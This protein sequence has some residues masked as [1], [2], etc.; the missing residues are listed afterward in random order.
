MK[1]KKLI[2]NKYEQIGKIGQGGF[3]KVFL[4]KN[5]I[6]NKLMAIKRVSKRSFVSSQNSITLENVMNEKHILLKVNHPFIIKF[7]SSFQDERHLFYVMEYAKG[8]PI[9]KYLQ[10]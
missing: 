6:N 3:S 4:V 5:I 1:K 2:H 7:F 8:G 9:T 10:K